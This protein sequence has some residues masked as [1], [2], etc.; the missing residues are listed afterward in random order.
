[1]EH[2]LM[3]LCIEHHNEVHLIGM[4]TFSIKYPSVEEWLFKMGWEYE[5]YAEKWVHDLE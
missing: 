5:P 3:P 2:N 1:M 4:I